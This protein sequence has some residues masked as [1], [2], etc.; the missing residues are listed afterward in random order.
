MDFYTFMDL[1]NFTPGTKEEDEYFWS[2]V[3]EQGW[4][5]AGI[6]RVKYDKVQIVSVG[7]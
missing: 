6:W 7:P 1:K 2:L 3:I 4:V 5:Q